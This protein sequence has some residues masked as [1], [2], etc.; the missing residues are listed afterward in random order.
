MDRTSTN[1]FRSITDK[2]ELGPVFLGW[3]K[4]WY[5]EITP[6]PHMISQSAEHPHPNMKTNAPP[7]LWTSE[8]CPTLL[9]TNEKCSCHSLH[10]HTMISHFVS[11]TCCKSEWHILQVIKGTRLAELSCWVCSGCLVASCALWHSH[12]QRAANRMCLLY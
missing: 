12:H 3:V 11:L 7:P 6:C 1:R 10:Q 8:K 9:W 2:C 5:G 4:H